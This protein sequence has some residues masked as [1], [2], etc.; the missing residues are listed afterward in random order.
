MFQKSQSKAKPH[1]NSQSSSK[2]C[3]VDISEKSVNSFE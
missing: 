3:K 2:T 1:L